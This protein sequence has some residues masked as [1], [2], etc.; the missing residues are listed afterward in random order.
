MNDLA[1]ITDLVE[2]LA[3]LPVLCLG[4]VMLDRFVHGVVDR[5]SPEAPIPILRIE[6][7]QAMLGGAG[8][9]VRNL[10]A[11]GAAPRL[12]SVV[13]DDA[14]GR[15]VLSLV[16]AETGLLPDIL[17]EPGRQTTIKTRYVAGG[18]QILR[19][20]R[21]TVAPVSPRTLERAIDAALAAL[22]ECR[23]VILSDYAKGLIV[24]G[25]A[26]RLIAEA[27][28]QGKPVIVDPKGSD[29]SRYRGATIVT[30][31]RRELAEATRLP[32]GG[33]AEIMAAAEHL[34]AH[35]GAAGVLVTRGPEG[36]TLVDE[37]G[38]QHL[39]AEAREV[40]DVS[41]AGDTAAATLTAALA[42]GLSFPLAARLANVAAGIVVGK[43]GTA[44]V[45]ARELAAQLR[46]ADLLSGADKIVD[47]AIALERVRAWR[48]RGLKIGFTNGCFDLLHPGHVSLLSQ[49]R[50][51]CDRQIVA[52]NGD[53]SV[54]ALK[55]PTRP[56]QSEAARAAVLASLSSV[57]LVVIFSE[58]TP[59]SLIE[60]LR[61]DV[62][63]KGADY[64]IDRV[65]GAEFVQSHG[66][67]V[68]LAEL[69]PGH[70]T[71]ATLA[72]LAS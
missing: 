18:Q 67:R 23:A 29:Y 19:A 11:L 8:N 32:I 27:R 17:V 3:G 28:R 40:F 15:E 36:M 41:G 49:T 12:V 1:N 2:R 54:R 44:V 10:V 30:P 34:R 68:L 21:E 13:G 5:I 38:C 6:S 64:S 42:A 16:G 60:A 47:R 53:A 39:A 65:V 20:D 62:L 33:D 58:E 24:D 45:H 9:V 26:A 71:S 31:N 69:L 7:E 63:V 48:A 35:L 25:L 50:A 72:R 4:D 46:R 51:A 14:A 22:G 59:L 57:D 56:V 61:P 66:G 55:G 52:I 70:S 43:T 37:T